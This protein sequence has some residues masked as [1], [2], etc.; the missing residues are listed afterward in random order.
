MLDSIVL[1][2]F[3][4]YMEEG[5]IGN[6]RIIILMRVIGRNEVFGMIIDGLGVMGYRG[7]VV[8]RLVDIDLG[9]EYMVS[10]IGMIFYLKI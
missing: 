10:Y 4:F 6:V 3:F 1:G 7:R 8:E 9:K 2:E 5:W